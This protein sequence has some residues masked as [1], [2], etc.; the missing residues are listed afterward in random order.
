MIK[1]DKRSNFNLFRYQ[2]G[3][4]QYIQ[5]KKDG[6]FCKLCVAFG[7]SEGGVNNRKLGALV[8]KKCNDRKHATETFNKR[9]LYLQNFQ[10][11]VSYLRHWIYI[12]IYAN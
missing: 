9:N 8:L 6:V 5:P 7:K 10:N 3:L 1:K 11:I 2:G 12:Y 4:G